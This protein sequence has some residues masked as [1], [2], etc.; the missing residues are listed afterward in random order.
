MKTFYSY[1][2]ISI[3]GMCMGAADVIPGVSGGTIAF[4]T[5]I[6]EELLD[7]IKSVNKE[8]FKYLFTF[9]FGKLWKHIN[10]NFLL[11]LFLGI[12]ISLFS[13]AE[14]M[15]YLMV[16]QP[17]PL[18][19]FFFGLIIASAIILLKDIQLKKLSNIIPI[20][21]GAAIGAAI[22]LL[23]PAQT[24]NELWFIFI[25]GAIAIC[26]MI[27][28]GISGSFI[29]LLMGKY[30]FILNSL[31]SLNIPVLATFAAG[32]IIG[33]I[34][35]SHLLSWLLKRYYSTAISLLCGIMIGSLLKVWP[36]QIEIASGVSH[37]A[38][39]FDSALTT[40]GQV[41][42]AIIFIIIGATLVITIETI[43]KK[44]GNKK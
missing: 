3:K 39:P 17:I 36:W 20:L 32:A 44:V 22:C 43:A 8:A 24:P 1:L 26:A 19:S 6:Y 18:W 7:S 27:L 33:I 34:S 28:P 23:S 31:T 12:L 37:P 11:S 9:K 35:F 30:E 4:L 42:Q 2:L 16:H 15:K 21:I 25:S 41:P 40:A 29:L 14:L 5:G 10:G 13:L 38:L